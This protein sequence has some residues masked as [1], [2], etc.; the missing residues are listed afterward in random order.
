[1]S[2]CA[3]I[4]NGGL[5][6]FIE[7]YA[8]SYLIFPDMLPDI[9]QFIDEPSEQPY[10]VYSNAFA[11]DEPIDLILDVAREIEL[12]GITIYWTNSPPAGFL[13][14]ENLPKNIIFTGFIPND[15]YYRLLAQSRGVIALTTEEDCL[16]CAAY[17]AVALEVPALVSDTRALREFF[18]G[19]AVYVRHEC[20]PLI[21]TL[22]KLINP[23]IYFQYRENI[24]MIKP[25][26]RNST[27]N[28]LKELKKI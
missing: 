19:A 17:E 26:F 10:F 21:S 11:V 1:M 13:L 5:K 27:D 4:S 3:L 12:D 15:D 25:A 16:Q 20:A 23:A 8:T 9:E 14:R 24:Q 22:R 28:I 18:G 7:P 6:P 2:D